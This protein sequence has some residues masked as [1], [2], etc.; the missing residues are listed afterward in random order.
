MEGK[1]SLN[2]EEASCTWY[3]KKQKDLMGGGRARKLPKT[4]KKGKGRK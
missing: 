2:L 1:N 3:T 4:I